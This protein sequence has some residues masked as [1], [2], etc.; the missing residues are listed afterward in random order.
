MDIYN[1]EKI[2]REVKERERMYRRDASEDLKSQI[3]M[4]KKENETLRKALQFYAGDNFFTFKDK[5]FEARLKVDG[6]TACDPVGTL[7]KEVLNS[8]GKEK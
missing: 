6:N 4:L 5:P 7:A 3:E 1:V 8:L 2:C